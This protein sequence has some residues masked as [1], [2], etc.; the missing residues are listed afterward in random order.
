[1][2][3]MPE[4]KKICIYFKLSFLTSFY[5]THTILCVLLKTINQ[6]FSFYFGTERFVST[7][8]KFNFHS[9]IWQM[10]Y[11]CM[12]WKM[13]VSHWLCSLSN[14][15]VNLMKKFQSFIVLTP[16][17]QKHQMTLL[18][19]KTDLQVALQNLN[20]HRYSPIPMECIMW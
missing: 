17:S 13:G 15:N 12:N 5:C 7:P 20:L 19:G 6:L 2:E 10:W 8:L 4:R 3:T 18:W 9:F 16:T 1:M 14:E 11:T